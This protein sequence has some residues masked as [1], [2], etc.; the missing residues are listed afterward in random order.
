MPQ[1]L[2]DL[3]D[4]LQR[5]SLLREQSAPIGAEGAASADD[6][7]QLALDVLGSSCL[8][9]VR[10][11]LCSTN[12]LD[13]M[14]STFGLVY[15]LSRQ[16]F[17]ECTNFVRLS[18]LG[19]LDDPVTQQH[20]LRPG[21]ITEVCNALTELLV[22]HSP[23]EET[24]S[25]SPDLTVGS[26]L[27]LLCS[28][29]VVAK[30][31]AAEDSMLLKAGMGS[32]SNG[33]LVPF[34]LSALFTTPIRPSDASDTDQFPLFKTEDT[35]QLAHQLLVE[36]SNDCTDN[37]LEV[38]D[39]VG[40][41][42][43]WD[44]AVVAQNLD[45]PTANGR[46]HPSKLLL[47][48]TSYVGLQNVGSIC[49]MNSVLQQLFM[50]PAFRAAIFDLEVDP[51]CSEQNPFVKEFQA[52]FSHLQESRKAYHEPYHL[53]S[54]LKG[55]HG[56]ELDLMEQ[57]DA[58][59]FFKLIFAKLRKTEYGSTV[60][61][62][63]GGTFD[64]DLESTHGHSLKQEELFFLWSIGVQGRSGLL[65][66]L[67][68]ETSPEK[69]HFCW[70][71][72]DLLHRH[73]NDNIARTQLANEPES[74]TKR[75]RLKAPPKHLMFHL[76]RFKFD[77]ASLQTVKVNDSFDVPLNIDVQ[78]FTTQTEGD[79]DLFK[80]ELCGVVMHQGSADD[81][82]YYSYIKERS[83]QQRWMKF[84]DESVTSIDV[85]DV[86]VN[87]SGSDDDDS[88][89]SAF[90]LIYD[91]VHSQCYTQRH[92]AFREF[93]VAS[94]GETLHRI[95]V[96]RPIS[97]HIW[98]QNLLVSHRRYMSNAFHFSFISALFQIDVLTV[99]TEVASGKLGQLGPQ[100]VFGTLSNT[101][102][103]QD[104]MMWL[105]KVLPYY[106]GNVIACTWL[107][108]TLTTDARLVRAFLMDVPHEPTRN[109][110][111]QLLI[112]AVQT[113]SSAEQTA[114]ATDLLCSVAACLVD[115]FPRAT[116]DWFQSTQVTNGA[117]S[118]DSI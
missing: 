117:D 62:M 66:S 115:L 63:F 60:K 100:F 114:A 19:L 116:N 72:A 12:L 89:S 26:I 36:L 109:A 85:A 7:L 18:V 29:L 13:A 68:R 69:V 45:L 56:E 83:E 38:L 93:V 77:R 23:T 106:K 37:L 108:H 17:R 59:S 105:R 42:H 32:A 95:A 51:S 81:G 87:C 99:A 14:A 1:F 110:F 2:V 6:P 104:V 33:Q 46:V 64:T 67:T 11:V 4:V 55:W 65:E 91:R 118:T 113:I 47:P 90:I 96:P 48:S 71:G 49:Y 102:A 21:S 75:R 22:L 50:M 31:D 58:S 41:L 40:N 44:P 98:R 88:Q 28:I 86:I 9:P 30:R 101:V 39:A 111:V 16:L 70:S 20:L 112:V 57:S 76:K 73:Q 43:V 3:H 24:G 5:V 53:Y 107:L 74:T 80:Y 78:P 94:G 27:N 103:R 97:D 10:D 82:H 52:A 92:N 79:D 15:S 84:D 54:V 35:R 61:A 25:K 8:D 34:L